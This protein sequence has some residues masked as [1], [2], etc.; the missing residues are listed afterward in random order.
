M[1]L[2]ASLLNRRYVRSTFGIRLCLTSPFM[3][4]RYFV[5]FL[6]PG[7]GATS[8]SCFVPESVSDVILVSV[9]CLGPDFIPSFAVGSI[10]D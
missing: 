7:F 9:P 6:T 2:E 5:S 10:G 4:C 8:A 3:L 1:Q